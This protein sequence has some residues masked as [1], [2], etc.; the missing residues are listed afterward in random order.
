MRLTEL[1]EQSTDRMCTIHVH[2]GIYIV[3]CYEAGEHSRILTF[4]TYQEAYDGGEDWNLKYE[5]K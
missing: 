2:Q 4:N 1:Y 3:H 5:T